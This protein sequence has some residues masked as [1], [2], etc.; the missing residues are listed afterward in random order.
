VPALKAL[1]Q[2]ALQAVC[3]AHAET[4]RASAEAAD[5]VLSPDEVTR[6]SAA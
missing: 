2:Y 6:L 3:T 5:L 1:P 4:A